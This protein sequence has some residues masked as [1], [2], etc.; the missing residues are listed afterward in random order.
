MINI[1]FSLRNKLTIQLGGIVSYLT[2]ESNI[3][4]YV[5]APPRKLNHK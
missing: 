1:D 4:A 2:F 3:Q 5:L